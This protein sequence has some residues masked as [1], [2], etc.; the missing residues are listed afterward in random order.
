MHR[1][2]AR[3]GV[4]DADAVIWVISSIDFRRRKTGF[5]NTSFFKRKP[6][7]TVCFIY[8]LWCWLNAKSTSERLVA[9]SSLP[10]NLAAFHDGLAGI[11]QKKIPEAVIFVP[12]AHDAA[13]AARDRDAYLAV[14]RS[15]SVPA[16]DVEPLFRS[17]RSE[18]FFF[19]GVHLNKLG[20]QIVGKAAAM[21]AETI[22]E[23]RDAQ[24]PTTRRPFAKQP[25][26]DT[27]SL[28]R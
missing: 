5:E 14:A 4:F 26:D 2:I 20:H 28:R 9:D 10:A 8:T 22:W 1:F 6:L 21:L 23:N 24:F 13:S 11:E 12:T 25:G 16:L 15:V 27:V 18:D 7:R 17:K 19:D 3:N